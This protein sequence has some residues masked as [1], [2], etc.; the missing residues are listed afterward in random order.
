MKEMV[1]SCKNIKHSCK[2][3]IVA[4]GWKL[5]GYIT[6]TLWNKHMNVILWTWAYEQEWIFWKG[7]FWWR[8]QKIFR[9]SLCHVRMMWKIFFHVYMDENHKMDENVGWK[10]NI[11]ELFGW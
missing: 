6:M 4:F 5:D 10:L 9:I 3:W 8:G 2:W 1:T 11:N 7:I